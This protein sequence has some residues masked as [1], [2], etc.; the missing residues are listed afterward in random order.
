M[1]KSSSGGAS[2]VIRMGYGADEIY[3]RW[4]MRS[5]AAWKNLFLVRARQPELFQRTGVLWT[6]APGHAYT[7]G[8]HRRASL[9]LGVKHLIMDTAELR[10]RYPAMH[11]DGDMMGRAGAGKAELLAYY[12]AS[13]Q[14]VTHTGERDRAW[15]W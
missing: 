4:A 2:R 12:R 9:G 10:R 3:T 13:V 15:K 8:E 7:A 11:F 6:A 5:L 14:A 1:P